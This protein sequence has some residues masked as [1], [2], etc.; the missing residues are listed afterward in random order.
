MD[1]AYGGSITTKTVREADWLFN[2]LAKNNYQ[3]PSKRSAGRRQGG[4]HDVDRISSLE[5]KFDALMTKLN[6]QNPKEPT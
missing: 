1:A 2:E 5:V 3:A 6:Q 4:M